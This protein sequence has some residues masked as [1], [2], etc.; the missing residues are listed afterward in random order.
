VSKSINNYQSMEEAQM[1]NISGNKISR[2]LL[3]A[4]GESSR[5]VHIDWPHDYVLSGPNK[6]RIYYKDLNLEHGVYG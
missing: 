5:H 4:G 1:G 3:R 2:G 6:E